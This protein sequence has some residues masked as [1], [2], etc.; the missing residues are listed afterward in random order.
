MS[1]N[2]IIELI[3]GYVINAEPILEVC[4]E[5]NEES[6]AMYI[7][8]KIDAYNHVITLIND[9]EKNKFPMSGYLTENGFESKD[10]HIH[11]GNISLF[12]DKESAIKYI[13]DLKK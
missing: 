9:A 11:I 10:E 5:E 4:I 2:E 7:K 6:N 1:E 3:E 8:G 12:K 13:N